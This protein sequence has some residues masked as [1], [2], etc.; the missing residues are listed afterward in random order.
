M[1][2]RFFPEESDEVVA[3]DDAHIDLVPG[4]LGEQLRQGGNGPVVVTA[5]ETAA[6]GIPGIGGFVAD[7]SDLERTLAGA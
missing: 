4:Q 3:V 5:A 2:L 1:A 6:R 7:A